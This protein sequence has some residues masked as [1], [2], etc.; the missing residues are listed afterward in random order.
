MKILKSSQDSVL[1]LLQDNKLGQDNLKKEARLRGVDPE[2]ILFANRIPVEDHLKRIG[3]IDLFLDTF[4]YNAHTTAR[5]AIKMKVPVITIIGES[6][7]S[8]VSGSLLS[9]IGLE[10]LIV[11]N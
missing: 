6:F 7:V 5:E 9:N 8:R 1:W 3:L 10:K 2:R 4:P 11:N